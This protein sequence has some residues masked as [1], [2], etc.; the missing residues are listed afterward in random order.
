MDKIIRVNMTELTVT[1][2]E[3]PAEWVT[4]GGRGID[5]YRGGRR[6]TADLSSPGTE[7]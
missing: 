6:G 7:Q 4:L 5:Q 1:T 2:E 3:V